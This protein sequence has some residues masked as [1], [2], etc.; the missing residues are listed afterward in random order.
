MK[1]KRLNNIVE[2][3]FDVLKLYLQ[4]YKLEALEGATGILDDV[5]IVLTEV[6]FVPTYEFASSFCNVRAFMEENGLGCST[7]IHTFKGPTGREDWK[8]GMRSS[9][10]RQNTIDMSGPINPPPSSL[11][12]TCKDS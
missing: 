9:S 7:F 1:Q 4:G 5:G 10:T 11:S 6:Q 2:G 8:R 3:K 12:G